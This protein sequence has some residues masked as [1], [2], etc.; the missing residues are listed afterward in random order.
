MAT[1]QY[2]LIIAVFCANNIVIYRINWSQ[3][4][5]KLLDYTDLQ[6]FKQVHIAIIVSQLVDHIFIKY[7]TYMLRNNIVGCNIK[8]QI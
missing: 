1:Q 3:F 5:T 6:V 4:T 8:L 7:I 2:Y